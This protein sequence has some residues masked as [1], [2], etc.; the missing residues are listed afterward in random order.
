MKGASTMITHT[1]AQF[2]VLC[3]IQRGVTSLRELA[4]A[5]A[6][7]PKAAH[8]HLIALRRKG[9]VTWEPSKSRTLRLRAAPIIEERDGVKRIVSFA[10]WGEP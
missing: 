9:Y 6:Y 8:D 4:A 2:A 7:T 5:G 10:K 1:P 3:R